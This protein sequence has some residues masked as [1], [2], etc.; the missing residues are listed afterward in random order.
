MI[1][2]ALAVWLVMLLLA[3][4]NGAVRQAWLIPRLGANSGRLV[5]TIALSA[6]IG[7]VTWFTIAWIRP[8]S[9]GDTYLVGVLWVAL[10]LAFEFLAGHFLFGSPWSELL[11]D[12]HLLRG[13]IWPLVLL[14]MA[15]AP[16]LCAG[17]RG[18]VRPLS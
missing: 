1:K 6:L 8:R 10:T 3:I 2:R 7:V 16:R 11:E 13:R 17:C 12:Y 14:T 4:I 15:V 9:S 5:S 18:L